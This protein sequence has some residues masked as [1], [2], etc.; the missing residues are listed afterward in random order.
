MN[1]DI[2]K[3][4]NATDFVKL[5][6]AI[7]CSNALEFEGLSF[8]Q[9]C[10]EYDYMEDD[11]DIGEPFVDVGLTLGGF[12]QIKYEEMPPGEITMTLRE[13]TESKCSNYIIVNIKEKTTPEN[14]PEQTAQFTIAA[15][16]KAHCG[17]LSKAY[18]PLDTM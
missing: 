7:P 4:V 6:R 18:P 8:K 9:K 16:K 5:S 12:H 2:F 3:A 11:P 15:S 13:I 1:S 10:W 14:K 17:A